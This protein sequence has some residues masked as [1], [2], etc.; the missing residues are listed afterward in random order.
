MKVLAGILRISW[1]LL[2][3][4]IT[5]MIIH[6]VFSYFPP[7]FAE[8][9]LK[10]KQALFQGIYAP[11]FYLHV[12][13]APLAILIG[14]LQALGKYHT[15][16]PLLHQRLGRAYVGTILF[17]AGP[18]G[19][20]MAF[21]ANGG[22]WGKASFLL[23]SILWLLTTALGYV[24]V[25]KRNFASHRNWMYRSYVLAS[26][27]IWLRIGMFISNSMGYVGSEAYAVVSWLSWLPF[28]LILELYLRKKKKRRIAPPPQTT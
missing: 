20:V 10:G 5:G 2:A 9:F 19:L 21:Y 18:G 12:I 15:R 8:G 24:I 27:A 4:L 6:L 11:A 7:N 28:L 17:A 23:L 26:S 25:L 14:T 3:V 16:W 1:G 13:G 22:I